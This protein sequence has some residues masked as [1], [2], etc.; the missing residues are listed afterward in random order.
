MNIKEWMGCHACT[1]YRKGSKEKCTVGWMPGWFIVTFEKACRDNEKNEEYTR[2]KNYPFTDLKI[3]RS[4]KDIRAE[5]DYEPMPPYKNKDMA[6]RVVY[7]E[8]QV[9]IARLHL[10]AHP[11]QDDHDVR[12]ALEALEIDDPDWKDRIYDPEIVGDQCATIETLYTEIKTKDDWIASLVKRFE[13]LGYDPEI[14]SN[15][16]PVRKK[17]DDDD[18]VSDLLFMI[19]GNPEEENG[20]IRSAIAEI[21]SLRAEKAKLES[22]MV[23][24]S[25]DKWKTCT[26]HATGKCRICDGDTYYYEKGKPHHDVAF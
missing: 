11:D 25:C 12:Y 9:A 8:S 20:T 16:I 24:C 19:K 23:A 26:R 13:S 14:T 1:H 18:I 3:A 4:W 5:C 10:E 21:E 22:D 6:E 15:G 7:L 2:D 17:N